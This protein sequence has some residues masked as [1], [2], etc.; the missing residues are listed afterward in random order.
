MEEKYKR[1]ILD[2]DDERYLYYTDEKFGIMNLSLKKITEPVFDSVLSDSMLFS[3]TDPFKNGI[4]SVQVGEKWG[5]VDINGKTIGS[6]EYDSVGLFSHGFAAVK[7]ER[8][9]GLC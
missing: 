1:L 9:M 3:K 5:F 7:K 4:F 8:K 2:V 6:I